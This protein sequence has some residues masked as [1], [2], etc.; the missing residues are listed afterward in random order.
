M[1]SGMSGC[2]WYE[3]VICPCAIAAWLLLFPANIK[4]GRFAM[5]E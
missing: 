1:Q 4:L 3:G 5:R 2:P